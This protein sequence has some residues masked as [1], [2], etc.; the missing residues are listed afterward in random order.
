M[1][2]LAPLGGIVIG[3]SGVPGTYGVCDMNG[4]WL[5]GGMLIKE[6]LGPVFGFGASGWSGD[7]WSGDWRRGERTRDGEWISEEGPE[8]GGESTDDLVGRL[9]LA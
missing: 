6:I 9:D 7:C 4:E 5:G 1:G 3:L 8:V 2:V